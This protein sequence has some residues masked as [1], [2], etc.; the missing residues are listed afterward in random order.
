MLVSGGR[1]A[2][3]IFAHMCVHSN[4]NRCHPLFTERIILGVPTAQ[5]Q[6]SGPLGGNKQLG[7][8]SLRISFLEN[9]QPFVT[10]CTRNL[11]GILGILITTVEWGLR[12]MQRACKRLPE[13]PSKVLTLSL[14]V[15]AQSGSRTLRTAV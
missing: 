11:H 8:P 15:C 4:M 3:R 14:V 13:G 1:T 10:R 12:V 9:S 6:L 7:I 5:N 2:C